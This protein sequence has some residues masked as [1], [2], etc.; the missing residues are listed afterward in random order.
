M[1]HVI[2]SKPISQHTTFS[3]N[4]NTREYTL[5]V[6]PV[7]ILTEEEALNLSDYIDSHSR[8]EVGPGAE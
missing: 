7:L 2:V 6:N 3:F 4:P 8:T 5:Y 1:T